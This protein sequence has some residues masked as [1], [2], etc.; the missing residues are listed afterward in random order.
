MPPRTPA[1]TAPKKNANLTKAM[2]LVEGG[3]SG[4]KI[5]GLT[6]KLEP[7]DE[8]AVF[9]ALAARPSP[10]GEA[11]DLLAKAYARAGRFA[12]AVRA[13]ERG[14]YPGTLHEVGEAALDAGAF[15]EAEAAFAA[16]E[17]PNAAALVGLAI[18]QKKAGKDPKAALGRAE[19]ANVAKNA[20]DWKSATSCYEHVGVAI[21]KAMILA[22]GG[23]VAAAK[24]SLAEAR[25]VFAQVAQKGVRKECDD[26]LAAPADPQ[27]WAST[28]ARHAGLG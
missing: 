24:R 26:Q 8:V 19:K 2:K 18:A 7:A 27:W 25:T 20:I 28:L 3:A 21:A 11:P 13:A 5:V 4:F 22:V 17:K 9:E 16:V 10:P 1:K 23:D 12:D 6:R 14:N 15:A